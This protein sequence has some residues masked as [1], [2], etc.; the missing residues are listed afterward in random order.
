MDS[1]DCSYLPWGRLASQTPNH[2]PKTTL[3]PQFL[4]V[5][6]I[7][8]R[9]GL[10]ACYYSRHYGV[11]LLLVVNPIRLNRKLVDL[12]SPLIP[13]VRNSTAPSCK[14]CTQGSVQSTLPGLYIQSNRPGTSLSATRGK[15][16]PGSTCISPWSAI[17]ARISGGLSF[18]LTRR[19]WIWR[20]CPWPGG[21][22]RQGLSR[23]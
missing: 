12:S 21:R 13:L 23:R 9:N 6:E 19:P 16:G 17:A 15:S 1:L 11:Q 8:K 22:R 18:I 10:A 2:M 5:G 3:R 20:R 7:S 4:R 14:S